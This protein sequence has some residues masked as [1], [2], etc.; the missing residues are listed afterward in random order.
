MLSGGCVGSGLAF[1]LPAATPIVDQSCFERTA[2][3]GRKPS[4]LA[5]KRP[6]RP[7]KTAV[8]N[9]IALGTR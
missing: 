5:V 4:F 3:P 1:V 9:R 2:R 8:E 6:A 7:Q